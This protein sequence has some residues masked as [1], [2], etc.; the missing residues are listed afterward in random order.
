MAALFT[1]AIATSLVVVSGGFVG[2]AF[3]AKKVKT[4]DDDAY[5]TVPAV[6]LGKDKSSPPQYYV[7]TTLQN[8]R[9]LMMLVIQAGAQGTLVVSLQRI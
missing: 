7:K 5:G 4:Q 2:S 6:A 9:A 3:A 1:I 8:R